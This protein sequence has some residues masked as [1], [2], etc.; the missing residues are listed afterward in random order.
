MFIED[1][2]KD[3]A[4]CPADFRVSGV[5][6]DDVL[7]KYLVKKLPK[8]VR[9]TAIM[10]CCH[11]GTALLDLDY[12]YEAKKQSKKEKK[13]KLKKKEKKKKK[14]KKK[15]DD[16]SD[17]DS[18]D[19]PEDHGAVVMLSGCEDHQTSADVVFDGTA[20]GA[21]SYALITALVRNSMNLRWCD[22]L[23]EIRKILS[24]R[25][26]KEQYPLLSSDREDFDFE[27]VFVA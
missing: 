6:I 16:D 26:R 20:T 7:H 25:V 22:L 1:D 13:K 2:G 10:D 27:S 14:K 24:K 8:G 21:M 9:L 15:K 5:I 11:S 17:E 18:E 23:E 12:I 3:E 19:N 4:I